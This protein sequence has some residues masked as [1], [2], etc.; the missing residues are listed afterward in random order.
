MLSCMFPN[1]WSG[2]CII[3]SD[4]NI[5]IPQVEKED[6]SQVKFTIKDDNLQN[7]TVQLSSD[8]LV[9]DLSNFLSETDTE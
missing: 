7:Y 1:E 8:E 6:F 5:N 3:S 4:I 9:K 2:H